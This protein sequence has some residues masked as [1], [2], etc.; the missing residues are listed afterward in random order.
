METGLDE[1]EVARRL[2]L[3]GPNEIAS[4]SRPGFLQLLLAQ[5]NNF[6]ILLLIG[7]AAISGLLGEWI[8][9]SA[10]LAIVILNA[11]LGVIQERRAEEALAALK[12]LAAPEAQVL[13][14]GSRR[15]VPG[16]ELVP[17]DIVFIE[18][19]N[20]V[21][22]D[23]RLVEAVNLRL[24]EAALTGES[25]PVQ[26]DADVRL[27]ADV[28][29]GDRKNTTFMGT[30]VNSGRGRGLVVSTGMHTQIGLIAAM[31]Q[32]VEKETTPLQKR[33]DGLGKVL[34]MAAMAVCALVFASRHPARP[35]APGDVHARR[36]AGHRRRARRPAGGGDHQPGA[37]HA[38]NGQAPRPDPPPVVGGDPRL[39]HRH[40]LGQDRH[41]DPEQ[42]DRHPLVGRRPDPSPSPARAIPWTASSW[43]ANGRPAARIIPPCSPPCGSAP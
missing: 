9:A 35:R 31:L 30:L 7:A 26:K 3:Y 22:A 14:G 33:L 42:D 29:L 2:E 38:R 36:G 39:D 25:V 19:G 28:P 34:G 20:F 4:A 23:L 17:G 8:D 41:A 11:T 27:E 43:T 10:I 5:F 1:A 12:K 6:I 15:T 13:R 37:G 24:E 21:P 16:P 18:A 32:S 40:L